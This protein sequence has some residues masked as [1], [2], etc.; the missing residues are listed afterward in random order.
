MRRKLGESLSTVLKF[1]TRVEQ[2]SQDV[3]LVLGLN[4]H[5]TE[6]LAVRAVDRSKY[7]AVLRTNFRN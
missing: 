6:Q 1:D 7:H 5:G 4:L 3:V 2:V